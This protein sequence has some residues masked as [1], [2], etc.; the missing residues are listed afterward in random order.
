MYGPDEEAEEGRDVEI[1]YIVFYSIRRS[2]KTDEQFDRV[3][4][5]R[6]RTWEAGITNGKGTE[7]KEELEEGRKGGG[8]ETAERSGK[9]ELNNILEVSKR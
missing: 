7:K 4:R 8:E 2:G 5:M 3:I 1:G 9:K 6:K